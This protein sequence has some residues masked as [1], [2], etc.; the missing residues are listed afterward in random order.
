MMRAERRAESGTALLVTVLMLTIMG[1]IGVA[2]MDTVMRERQIAGFHKRVQ[3]SLY[4][5][6]AGISLGM[7]LIR[8]DVP[9]LAPL[10]VAG[11]EAYDPSGE[12]PP[13]FPNSGAP[14]ML[15]A[16]FPAPGSPSF[17]LDPNASDPDNTGAPARAV[18]YIGKG[19]EC[20]WI[21]SAEANS[22]EWA[23]A[24]WDIR[25]SGAS[26]GGG[27]VSIQAVGANCHPY[28]S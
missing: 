6:E 27:L 23:E 1:L 15:G 12:T 19:D 16:D 28:G 13:R 25:V 24:L 5:A 8:S 3:P 4:A 14:T 22:V 26:P 9:A 11:L 2:S 21:M 10:G 17:F 20:G 7:A 18:R